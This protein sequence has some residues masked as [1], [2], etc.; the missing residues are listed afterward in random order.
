MNYIY[1]DEPLGTL[2]IQQRTKQIEDNK[3]RQM[4]FVRIDE[5]KDMSV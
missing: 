4:S 3:L 5:R 2:F 1:N